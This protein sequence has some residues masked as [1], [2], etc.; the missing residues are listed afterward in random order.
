[1][2]RTTF[3]A[4]KA[5]QQSVVVRRRWRAA[6]DGRGEGSEERVRRNGH[7]RNAPTAAPRVS[8]ERGDRGVG[9][10]GAI[11][12]NRPACVMAW[13]LDEIFAAA[14]YGRDG[15]FDER[16]AQRNPAAGRHARDN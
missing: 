16:S 7:D 5:S 4:R 12:A 2:R 14:C 11:A 6:G 1:M 15:C 8:L 13:E 9:A 3:D 10:G